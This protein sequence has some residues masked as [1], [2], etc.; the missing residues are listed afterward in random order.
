M[1]NSITNLS[2]AHYHTPHTCFLSQIKDLK[3]TKDQLENEL[4]ETKEEKRVLLGDLQSNFLQERASSASQISDLAQKLNSLE[5]FKAKKIVWT[6]QV[7]EQLDEV[8][9]EG[10]DRYY[11]ERKPFILER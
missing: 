9:Y 11:E 4:E 6:E 1:S 5:E 10:P 7:S 2:N 8:V 3:K